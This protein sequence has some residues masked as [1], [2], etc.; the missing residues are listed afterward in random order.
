MNSPLQNALSGFSE[1]DR[2]RLQVV[3]K[4][5]EHTRSRRLIWS[6]NGTT[7]EARLKG[8]TQVGFIARDPHNALFTRLFPGNWAQF[9][10]RRADGSEVFKVEAGSLLLGVENPLGR[11]ELQQAVSELF[12]IIEQREGEELDRILSELG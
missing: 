3:Q 2:R 12:S 5:I 9:S 11:D 7:Y 1:E 10:V 6:K 8:G 4:L